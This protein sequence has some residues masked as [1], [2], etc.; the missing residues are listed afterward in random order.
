MEYEM[1]LGHSRRSNGIIAA[2]LTDKPVTLPDMATLTKAQ[3]LRFL[4]SAVGSVWAR[5]W[6]W[7][8]VEG[9]VARQNVADEE[10]LKWEEKKRLEKER[11]PVSV[12]SASRSFEHVL[13]LHSYPPTPCLYGFEKGLRALGYDVDVAASVSE[14]GD[15]AQFKEME[16]DYQFV[17]IDEPYPT[18]ESLYRKVGRKPEW[19]LYLMPNTFYFPPDIGNC[20][21]PTVGWLTEEYKQ[22]SLYEHLYC[23]FDAAPTSFPF[24]AERDAT[25]GMDNR[26]YFDIRWMNWQPITTLPKERDI[27]LCFIGAVGVPGVTDARDAEVR[28]WD[29]LK[30]RY[31]VFLGTN[32]WLRKMMDAYAR[33]K[34]VL[35]H[36]GQG[37][38]NLTFRIG[39]ATAA[40]AMVLAKRPDTGDL[41]GLVEN[42]SI[43]LYD[44]FE[45]MRNK[46]AYYLNCEEAR[47]QVVANA[48]KLM[49]GNNSLYGRVSR[50]ME[51]V[52]GIPEDYRERRARRIAQRTTKEP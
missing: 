47:Q 42:E 3:R 35:Q 31:R 46:A 2:I 40:G 28:Q 10:R 6:I 25:L 18:M 48:Q 19:V 34:I 39:E 29:L 36:S 24:M 49:I 26:P 13:I 44:T 38:N 9:A 7:W 50:F 12:G 11:L 23:R 51:Q 17:E 1:P 14:Y 8:Q 37:E 5:P 52:K 22:R 4:S 41:A 15:A 16:P 45:D 33:S 32:I 30:S 20:A 21:M 27:D 43:V